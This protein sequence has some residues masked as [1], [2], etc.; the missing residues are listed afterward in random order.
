MNH[1]KMERI[2]VRIEQKTSQATANGD[3]SYTPQ[4]HTTHL[5]RLKFTMST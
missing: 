2:P 5:P 3:E 4:A 1:L